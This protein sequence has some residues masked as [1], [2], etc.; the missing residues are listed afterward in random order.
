[1]LIAAAGLFL[2][3]GGTLKEAGETFNP[4][5]LGIELFIRAPDPDIFENK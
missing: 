2:C 3:A 5:N 4:E 1:M